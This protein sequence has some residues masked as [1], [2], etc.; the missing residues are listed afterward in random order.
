MFSK[1]FKKGYERVCD[2]M[3]VVKHIQRIQ[4]LRAVL[5]MI[6]D[7]DMLKQAKKQYF[8]SMM[9]NH[10]DDRPGFDKFIRTDYREAFSTC[11]D[12]DFRNFLEENRP[13]LAANN[14]SLSAS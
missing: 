10:D 11:Q 14:M 7:A 4:K 9:I 2:E 5:S 8:K 6:T 3:D 13:R 12:P 1:D